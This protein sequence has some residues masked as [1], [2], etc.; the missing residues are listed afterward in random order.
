VGAA[1]QPEPVRE[2]FAAG[3]ERLLG[4][5]RPDAVEDAAL[6]RETRARNIK[7]I[8]HAVGALVLSRACP[9]DSPLADEILGTCRSSA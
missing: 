2:V 1:R 5:L 7:A 4:A 8:A 3:L 9:D 6:S